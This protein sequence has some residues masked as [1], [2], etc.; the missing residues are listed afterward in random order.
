ME[1]MTDRHTYRLFHNPYTH[2]IA[3]SAVKKCS[4]KRKEHGNYDRPTYIRLFHNPFPLT[5]MHTY[6]HI[7]FVIGKHQL[8]QTLM[9]SS[10]VMEIGSSMSWR[11]VALIDL[12]II[13]LPMLLVA[14]PTPTSTGSRCLSHF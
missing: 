4:N 6:L 2:F 12:F 13:M 9:C 8:E 11:L 5:V 3:H 7:C 14:S 1:I 10:T